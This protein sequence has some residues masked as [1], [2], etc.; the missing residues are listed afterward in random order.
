MLSNCWIMLPSHVMDRPTQ[1]KSGKDEHDGKESPK[2]PI[3]RA[4]GPTGFTYLYQAGGTIDRHK[5]VREYRISLQKVGPIKL[6][7]LSDHLS[8]VLGLF[9]D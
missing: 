3:R 5:F 6:R 2:K 4:S 1:W 7:S 8:T 9:L